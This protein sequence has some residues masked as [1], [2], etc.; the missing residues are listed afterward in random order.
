MLKIYTLKVLQTSFLFVAILTL[1]IANSIAGLTVH[2]EIRGNSVY[3][4]DNYV[5]TVPLKTTT[6]L[7]ANEVSASITAQKNDLVL[8]MFSCSFTNEDSWA[9]NVTSVLTEG[10]A[11]L[12]L[13]PTTITGKNQYSYYFSG[14]N[15]GLYKALSDGLL[16]FQ[17]KIKVSG[18]RANVNN[19]NIFALIIGTAK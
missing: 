12:L 15:F 13:E 10:N 17:A 18:G 9:T 19:I 5:D 6:E 7:I 1:N 14:T 4:F 16:K 3:A 11:V 2:G 8:V